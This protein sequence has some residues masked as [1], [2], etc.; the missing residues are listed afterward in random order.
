MQSGAM[1]SGRAHLVHKLFGD[2]MDGD[3]SA[4]PRMFRHRERA[5]LAAPRRADSPC[6]RSSPPVR[7]SVKLP[8]V[9]LR[10]ALDD[11]ARDDAGRDPVPVVRPPSRTR[12][13]SARSVDAR[14]GDAPRDDRRSRPCRAPSRPAKRRGRRSPTEHV[15]AYRRQ[16]RAP[17]PCAPMARR[18]FAI[19]V[20][21]GRRCRRPRRRRR[22]PGLAMP[23]S[24][25]SA[26]TAALHGTA[27]GFTPPALEMILMPLARRTAGRTSRSCVRKSVGVSPPP[28][29]SGAASAGSPW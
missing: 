29:A 5:V 7:Q 25:A 24:S 27:R 8:P 16:L 14:V 21:V 11:V 13:S 15:V 3:E 4:G 23:S 18:P 19:C 1:Y 6:C 20:E 10:A 12:G 26:S 22:A 17:S 9:A 28:A 2:R